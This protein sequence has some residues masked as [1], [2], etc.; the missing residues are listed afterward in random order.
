M[1][2]TISIIQV[3]CLLNQCEKNYQ[4]VEKIFQDLPVVQNHLVILPELWT[5]GFTDDLENV[6]HK[7]KELLARLITL[8]SKTKTVIAGSFIIKD[9]ENFFNRLCVVD[10]NK[11]IGTYDKVHLFPQLNEYKNFQSGNNLSIVS[12]WGIKIGMA[13][14][15]DLRFPEIFRK[16]AS[17]SVEICIIPA[18]WPLK[19]IDHYTTLLQARAI[20]NQ[21]S[22][23]SANACGKIYNTEFGGRSS[24]IDHFGNQKTSSNRS[25]EV[26]TSIINIDE[27]YKWRKDFPVLSEIGRKSDLEIK[28]F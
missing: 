21:M 8:A 20:E 26:I 12:I 3:E 5:S 22:I 23:V 16:Y 6:S 24:I 18:Q 10:E 14:C 25:E 27:L 15:Y 9:R 13:I 28:W 7:N 1:N 11:I 2:I 4:K 19:R 17:H